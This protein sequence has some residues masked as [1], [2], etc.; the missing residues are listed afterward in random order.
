MAHRFTSVL[1]FFLVAIFLLVYWGHSQE[2][3]IFQDKEKIS[4]HEGPQ[5]EYESSANHVFYFKSSPTGTQFKLQAH[6]LKI[7][8]NRK[9]IF[10]Q[11]LQGVFLDK[12]G[13]S[14]HFQSETAEYKQNQEILEMKGMVKIRALDSQ[15][16]AEQVRY[17][18][19]QNHFYAQG[20]I[21]SEAKNEQNGDR[22]QTKSQFAEA[23]PQQKHFRYWGNV[24]GKIKR[25]RPFEQDVHFSSNE[26][27][28]NLAQQLITLEGNVTLKKQKLKAMARRGEIYLRNYNKRLKYYVLSD[29]VQLVETLTPSSKKSQDLKRR[30]Y[31]EKLEGYVNEHKV[32]LSGSPRV[33][34]GKNVIHGNLITLFENTNVVEIDDA[35][36]KLIIE[37]KRDK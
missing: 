12:T 23:W 4:L 18:G 20:N 37:Q 19:A 21:R 25:K 2:I 34:Q 16:E 24:Q 33:V 28:L 26:I 29:D 11:L 31:G 32:V 27:D 3:L 9:H 35:A 22:I 30:A 15:L 6:F 7:K 5:E 36:S 8:K 17:V 14:F 1:L 13:Q 10:F